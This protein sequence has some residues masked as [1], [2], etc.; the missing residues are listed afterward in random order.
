M[1][2]VAQATLSYPTLLMPK[3]I[4]G[5]VH[6]TKFLESASNP[7]YQFSSFFFF[8]FH[9]ALYMFKQHYGDNDS[10]VTKYLRWSVLPTLQ[11]ILVTPCIFDEV[12]KNPNN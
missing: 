7:N 12:G 4:P 8:S 5:A 3:I 6:I 9:F 11:F 2:V 1:L 10:T